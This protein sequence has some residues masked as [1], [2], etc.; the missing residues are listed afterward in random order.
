[1]I[2]G[3]IQTLAQQGHV[4]LALETL[5]ELH[6]HDQVTEAKS[7]NSGMV[8]KGLSSVQATPVFAAM[9]SGCVATQDMKSARLVVDALKSY[10]LYDTT[11]AALV[12]SSGGSDADI[13]ALLG[14]VLTDEE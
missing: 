13:V 2:T 3:L 9:L 14:P 8:I 7:M 5:E 1:M 12:G 4:E 6:S 10:G 11:K